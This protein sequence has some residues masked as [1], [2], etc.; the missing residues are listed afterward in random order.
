MLY[1][2]ILVEGQ[3]EAEFVGILNEYLNPNQIYLKPV[4]P[5]TSN[6]SNRPAYRGGIVSYGKAE[7]DIRKLLGDKSYDLVT[8]MIDFYGLP[9]DFPNYSDK[10]ATTGTV[11]QRVEYL[12]KK[13][14]EKINR[15]K[16][17]PYFAIHEFEAL[18]FTKPDIIVQ[19]I[20]GDDIKTKA[21]LE[22][23][24]N[25]Y[26]NP[27][28]INLDKPP[29]KRILN[30]IKEYKKVAHGFEISVEIGIEAMR[31]ECPH[32]DTWLKKIEALST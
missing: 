4:L 28:E 12:E 15:Q 26:Q 18:L 30:A 2:L 22:K 11:Y 29:S 17:L 31:Q 32:F 7:N 16:F 1:I 14:K 21:N 6:P 5:K 23:I 3:T 25:S 13:F 24:R 20:R 9:T 8:T 19:Q 10:E 27:E